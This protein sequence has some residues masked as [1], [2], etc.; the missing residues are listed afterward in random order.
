MADRPSVWQVAYDAASAGYDPFTVALYK[1]VTAHL[2]RKH[3]RLRHS[4]EAGDV[5][6]H[7]VRGTPY[8]RYLFDRVRTGSIRH[9]GALS[10]YVARTTHQL[11]LSSIK[12]RSVEARYLQAQR[13]AAGD[14]VR[15]ERA[16]DASAVPDPCRCA[17]W[18]CGLGASEI[19]A[20]VRPGGGGRQ[21]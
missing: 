18:Q 2:A 11:I 1:A 14:D 16:A 12:R 4:V 21:G 19:G 17:D 5:I 6:L 8:P 3:R 13:R 20:E 7:H 15:R 9:Y 10:T